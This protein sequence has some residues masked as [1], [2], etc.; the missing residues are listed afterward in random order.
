MVEARLARTDFGERPAGHQRGTRMLNEAAREAVKEASALTVLYDGACPLCRRE[1]GVYRGLQPLHPDSPVFFA[2]VN[3]SALPLPP[4]TTR[5]QLVAL[6]GRLPGA[7][8]LME[9]GMFAIALITCA[10]GG[11]GWACAS[12][13]WPRE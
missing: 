12:T 10:S 6:A 4:G 5:E 7:G 2:D 8:W 9:A 13:E 3:D 11:I 1:I